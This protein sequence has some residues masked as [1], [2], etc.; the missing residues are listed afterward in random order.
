[1]FIRSHNLE[2]SRLS[3]RAPRAVGLVQICVLYLLCSFKKVSVQSVMFCKRSFC[4]WVLMTFA[5][6]LSL[7]FG[8]WEKYH[9]IQFFALMAAFCY[10]WYIPV[11]GGSWFWCQFQLVKTEL[12]PNPIFRTDFRIR[13]FLFLFFKNSSFFSFFFGWKNQTW[14]ELELIF[15][16]EILKKKTETRS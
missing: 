2:N 10:P 3:I 13:G 6:G 14:S 12:E 11:L 7:L 1:M 4:S 8:S 15:L 9:S 16:G 5:V